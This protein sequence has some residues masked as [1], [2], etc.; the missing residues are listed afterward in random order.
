M[1]INK[2][3][4]I[5]MANSLDVNY[6]INANSKKVPVLKPFKVEKTLGL[7]MP[8][9]ILDNAMKELR[10][11]EFNKSMVL[12]VG[13]S[14]E[15]AQ[16]ILSED[17]TKLLQV[18]DLPIEIQKNVNQAI[19]NIKKNGFDETTDKYSDEIINVMNYIISNSK[20]VNNLRFSLSNIPNI[21][22]NNYNYMGYTYPGVYSIK[23][24]YGSY[25]TARRV[26]QSNDSSHILIVQESG[27][28]D[29]AGSYAI[30]AFINGKVYG[31][32]SQYFI[33]KSPNG[34]TYVLLTWLIP[35]YDF[36]LYFV[37]KIDNQTK[38]ILFDIANSLSKI[39]IPSSHLKK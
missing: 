29:N 23:S 4:G 30:E 33:K 8:K 35:D 38:K 14:E 3:Q 11:I 7:A 36:S 6:S 18:K 19:A 9:D 27:L 17:R 37:G 5:D 15:G 22:L 2:P 13:F 32:P 34:N 28:N 25:G 21:I 1:Y 39:N 16:K 24:V 20:Q 31:Y 12:N 10:N 26:F